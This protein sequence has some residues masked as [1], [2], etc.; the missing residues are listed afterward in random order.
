MPN[1][2]LYNLRC[3]LLTAI[4]DRL[5]L[6]S[7]QRNMQFLHFCSSFIAFG[8]YTSLRPLSSISLSLFVKYYQWG[9]NQQHQSS[10][11]LIVQLGFPRQHLCYFLYYYVNCSQSIN[12]LKSDLGLSF[13]I[14]FFVFNHN[15]LHHL[16]FYF[17]YMYFTFIQCKV[18]MFISTT[19]GVG[20]LG[21]NVLVV[22]VSFEFW[23]FVTFLNYCKFWIEMA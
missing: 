8:S 16:S 14:V 13:C 1:E 10:L 18:V 2:S 4:K 20:K 5:L 23:V 6:S 7:L 9:L 19:C 15:F 17:N 12:D 22:L 3:R 21:H 11:H